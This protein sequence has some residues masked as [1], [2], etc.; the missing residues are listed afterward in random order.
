MSVVTEAAPSG[1]PSTTPALRSL[2][3]YETARLARHPVFVLGALW[4]VVIQGTSY[5]MEYADEDYD[6]SQGSETMLDW[7][8]LPAFMLGLAGLIAMNRLTTSS[9]RAG[10]VIGAVPVS[11]Q[12]RTLALCLAATLP[13]GLALLA[14]MSELM[15]W[16]INPPVN[17]ISWGEFTDAEIVAIMAAGVLAA[18]GGPLLGILVARWWRWP[19]A[20]A[21]VSVSLILW[22]LLSINVLDDDNRWQTVNHMASP[23]TL[24]AA[25]FADRSWHF[26]GSYGWRVAY[27]ACLCALAVLGAIARDAEGDGRRRLLRWILVTLAL[28]VVTLVLSAATGPEGY[29]GR[30]DP[31]WT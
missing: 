3:R 25:N 2:V 28:A 18:L 8:V 16:S 12:R 21:V 1:V 14:A 6:L 27:L 30:W 10:E 24:V 11:A 13:A 23:F 26:G 29:W 5:F 17:S 4:L 9:A 7:P 20:A 15:M 19:L 22:S 31:R